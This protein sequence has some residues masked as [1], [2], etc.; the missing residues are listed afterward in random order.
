MFLLLRAPPAGAPAGPHLAGV[1]EGPGAP[2]APRRDQPHPQDGA[3]VR[4]ARRPGRSAA[5]RAGEESE[6]QQELGLFLS[7]LSVGSPQPRK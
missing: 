3:G 4:P 7:C 5:G 6:T 1:P 2:A